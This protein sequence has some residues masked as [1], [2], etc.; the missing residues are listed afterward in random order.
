[1]VSLRQTNPAPDE[2]LLR[3]VA[4]G[5]RLAL[6]Q[7][8]L[9]HHRRLAHFLTRVTSRYES[10]EEIINDTFMVVWQRAADFRGASRVSTWITGIAY[11]IALKSL[12]G[13]DV[14]RR[15]VSSDD[16][17]EAFEEPATAAELQD[18]IARGVSQLPVEQRLTLHL[19]YQLGHSVDEIAEITGCPAGTVKARMFHAR[20]KLR[21]CLPALGGLAV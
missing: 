1:M 5:D 7:L 13:S 9:A 16:A 19:A 12:R 11:R 4:R 20:E 6:D 10:A 15:T 8:Y 3:A 18:W 17:P 14:M 21:R 2:E